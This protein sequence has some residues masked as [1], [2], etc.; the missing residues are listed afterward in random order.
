M[1]VKGSD[2]SIMPIVVNLGRGSQCFSILGPYIRCMYASQVS[3]NSNVRIE[4][5]DHLVN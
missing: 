2:K 1:D 3:C 4:E 5:A